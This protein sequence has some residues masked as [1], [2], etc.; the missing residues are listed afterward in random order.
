MDCL[1]NELILLI[2]DK[3][4]KNK[5][6]ASLLSTNKRFDTLKLLCK[7]PKTVDVGYH[8]PPGISNLK[9]RSQIKLEFR[10]KMDLEVPDYAY[11]LYCYGADLSESCFDDDFPDVIQKMTFFETD[12]L[13]DFLPANLTKLYIQTNYYDF[14][15]Y[16]GQIPETVEKLKFF[17][18]GKFFLEKGAIPGSVKKLVI[19]ALVDGHN[20]DDIAY[21]IPHS[22]T[23][24]KIDLSHKT[25]AY[26][27]IPG[28][29]PESVRHL[30]LRGRIEKINH[31]LPNSLITL[32]FDNTHDWNAVFPDMFPDTLETLTLGGHVYSLRPGVVPQHVHTL[33]ILNIHTEFSLLMGSIPSSVKTLKINSCNALITRG[34][35]PEGL[36]S[37]YIKNYNLPLSKGVFPSTIFYLRLSKDYDG[38]YKVG[39][40]PSSVRILIFGE[41]SNQ[42]LLP[43]CIPNGVEKLTF[44]KNYNIGL[45]KGVI[46]RT[47]THLRLGN[48]FNQTIRP[49][50]IP[51]SVT[52]IQTQ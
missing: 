12:F 35:L 43:G 7:F 34:M 42:P 26:K 19:K 16:R 2:A 18:N 40:I 22:V 33:S 23:N 52:K 25:N 47:V 21:I 15:I 44:G 37:L 13:P 50:D 39:V 32:T 51:N 14:R 48:M 31:A 17:G 28:F 10:Y 6:V 46:P 9:Y 49:G 24:L 11:S 27:I 4:N 8:V 20:S 29:I 41:S 1:P 30:V 5:K 45:R 38:M 36:E 3:L